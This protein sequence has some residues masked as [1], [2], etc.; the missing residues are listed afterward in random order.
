MKKFLLSSI[1]MLGV[2]GAVNAQ[3]ETGSKFKKNNAATSTSASASSITPQ[4]AA[5]M[6]PSDDVAVPAQATDSR[7]AAD[8][9]AA[10]AAPAPTRTKG[11]AK[12]A[13][14]AAS[15]TKVNAAVE[16]VPTDEAK[17]KAEKKKLL[18]KKL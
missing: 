18:L 11:Q 12:T 4:K 16:V 3:T 6:A 9:A 15:A 1:I 5:I 10:A 14:A 2:C 7:T 17:M 13:Q 8:K